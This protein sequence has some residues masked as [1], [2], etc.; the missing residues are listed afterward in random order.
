[1]LAAAVMYAG[2]GAMLSHATAAWWWR[3]TDRQPPL[4]HVSTPRD[5]HSLTGL[6]VHGRR[7]VE[8]VW[9]NGLTVTTVGR[10]SGCRGPDLART[11][12]RL[13]RAF[14]CLCESGGLPRPQVN[15]KVCGYSRLLLAPSAR[16]RR[17]GRGKG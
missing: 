7:G 5:C 17:A 12:S 6:K 15:V 9:R 3:L 11:R 2:P 4:I 14:L 8:R 1:E 16:G 10:A 13:E